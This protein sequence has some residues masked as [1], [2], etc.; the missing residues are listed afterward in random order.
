MS[1]SEHQQQT[2]AILHR[3]GL[4]VLLDLTIKLAHEQDLSSILKLVTAAVCEAHDCD[5]ASLFIYDPEKQDL[6][7]EVVTKL[8][9]AE[10]R[11]QPGESIVG[12]VAEHQQLLNVPDAYAEERFDATIDQ[13][14]GFRT[15]NILATPILSVHDGK[16]LGVLQVLNKNSGSFSLADEQLI[17]AFATHAGAAIERQQLLDEV[18]KNAQLQSAI[19]LGRQIQTSF[20]PTSMPKIPQYELAIWWEPAESVSGD[21]YDFVKLPDNR[22]GVM[23]ADVSGHGIG[24]S[25]IMASFRA[26]FRVLARNRSRVSKLF[27]LLA[28][29][30]YPDLQEGRFITA[31]FVAICPST[32]E[33]TYVNA[34]HAPALYLNRESGTLEDLVTTGFPIGVVPDLSIKPG[35]QLTIHPGDLVVLA[36]DGLIELR[37]ESDEMFGT[38]RLKSLILE[39]QSRPACEIRDAIRAAIRD[40]FPKSHLPDDITLLIIERKMS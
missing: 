17:Q 8:E 11:R 1:T 27:N 23:V 38:Q 12:W 37:N 26:M 34:G 20:L 16:L 35:P 29:S 36:T 9:I 18:Q 7:T 13:I 3:E 28:E 24:P 19:E 4:N 2:P 15:Q 25:L 40:F 32:H 31:I 39:H 14:T 6:H 10:I 21:Y 33:L 5:R 30:I 22:L